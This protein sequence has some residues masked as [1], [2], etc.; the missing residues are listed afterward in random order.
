MFNLQPSP[1]SNKGHLLRMSTCSTLCDLKHFTTVKYYDEFLRKVKINR[2]T[3]YTYVRKIGLLKIYK[4]KVLFFLTQWTPWERCVRAVRTL[5]ARR[6][7][8]V[9][10]PWERCV[11]TVRTLCA[12]RENAVCTLWT[13]CSNYL[14]AV[15]AS[16]TLWGWHPLL[17]R[18]IQG[19]PYSVF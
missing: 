3:E 10:A 6:E 18:S 2:Y 14:R 17:V 16:W 15:E 8:A 19:V 9:C 7:N 4:K 13:R 5:C 11:H 12:R 1:R